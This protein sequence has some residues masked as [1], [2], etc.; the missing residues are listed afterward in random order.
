MMDI[1]LESV[2]YYLGTDSS[3]STEAALVTGLINQAKAKLSIQTGRDIE[4][5][6]KAYQD[7]AVET[8]NAM[9]FL[10]YYGNRDDI[11]TAH[12]S[13]FI[14]SNVFLLTYAPKE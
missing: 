3:D 8:I 14:S 2:C 5:L 13:R 1:S 10:A 9:V 11:K 12:L 6:P 4:S 7:L